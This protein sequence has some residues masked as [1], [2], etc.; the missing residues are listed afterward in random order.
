MRLGVVAAVKRAY[1]GLVLSRELAGPRPRAGGALEAD[2]G[3]RARP[4]RGGPGRPAGRA[5]GPGR[6]DAR[7]AAAGR[8]GGREPDPRRRAQPPARPPG[9]D[10]RSDTTA[11][12]ALRPVA[13]DLDARARAARRRQ[14]RAAGRGRRARS[15][16]RSPW[17]S[18]SKEFKP[19]F[20]VQAGYMNRGGLDPMWQAGVGVSLPALPQAAP[21]GMAEA[22]A[23]VRASARLAES[24]EAAAPLPNRGAPGPARGDGEDRGALRRGHRPPG[25]HVGRGGGRQLPVRQGAVHR[26]ARGPDHPLQRPR[27]PPARC[28]PT[29][30]G[31]APAWRRRA[32]SPPPSL[33]RRRRARDGRGARAAA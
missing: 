26:R 14:P 29:T 9:R 18:R 24:V 22:E 11:R 25:P 15:G 3:R 31:S 2:R 23:Q 1:Y 19:D 21:S 10:A 32:S 7:R 28:W 8:A 4:L 33:R 13:E 12:L 16:P 30:S 20:S 5:A 27:H 17:R 6:G